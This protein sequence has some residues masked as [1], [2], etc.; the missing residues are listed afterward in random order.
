ML[1]HEDRLIRELKRKPSAIAEF[2]D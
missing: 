2:I 1:L